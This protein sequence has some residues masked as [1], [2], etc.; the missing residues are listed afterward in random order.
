MDESKLRAEWERKLSVREPEL[1]D[2]LWKEFSDSGELEYAKS[3]P[4][5]G[6]QDMVDSAKV[7][8][9]Y[10]RLGKK[11][12]PSPNEGRGGN[13][14]R[15]SITVP[16]EVLPVSSSYGG[17]DR[18]DAFSEYL[19]MKAADQP[20][21]K[22]FRREVVGPRRLLTEEALEFIRSPAAAHLPASWF[23][24]HR[25]PMVGHAAAVGIKES[26]SDKNGPYSVIEISVKPAGVTKQLKVR[27]RHYE[28]LAFPGEG[29]YFQRVKVLPWSV[30]GELL[31]LVKRL[32]DIYPWPEEMVSWFVLRGMG[33][34]VLPMDMWVESRDNEDFTYA[35][36][37]LKVEPWVSAEEVRT[38]FLYA[39]KL[40]L[41]R[42]K[43]NL[44][45]RNVAV[46][47]FVVGHRNPVGPDMPWWSG[48]DNVERP[49]WSKLC[50]LW[51]Q[52]HPQGHDWH[53]K[54]WRN[55]QRDYARTKKTLV[56]PNY[57]LSVR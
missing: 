9:K 4:E 33:I 27:S 36:V 30:L 1:L 55:F 47:F 2:E 31:K 53:Y 19:I 51:N 52:E 25:V 12:A 38:S 57:N 3:M 37:N 34:S 46:F 6:L 26:G 28:E 15:D 43:R 21:V 22:G 54:E 42:K 8:I 14:G 56:H 48:E 18:S 32:T 5:T 40:I 17:W 41:G 7:R 13:A 45:E 20:F 10:W 49:I 29:G 23:R 44:S 39:Q 24:K 11:S 35:T 16:R 50:E